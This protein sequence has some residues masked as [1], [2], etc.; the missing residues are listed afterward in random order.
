MFP[1]P[2]IMRGGVGGGPVRYILSPTARRGRAGEVDVPS[3]GRLY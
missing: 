1:N 2:T 3:E